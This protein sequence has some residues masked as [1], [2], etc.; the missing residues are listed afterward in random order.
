MPRLRPGRLGWDLA[1]LLIVVIASPAHAQ[2]PELAPGVAAALDAIRADSM[3]GHLSFLASDLLEGRDTPS[4]GLDLAAE[5]IAAQFRRAG[6]EPVGDDGYFQTARWKVVE[7]DPGTFRFEVTH[8]DQF[9]S[10]LPDRVSLVGPGPIDVSSPLVKLDARDVE[11]LDALP[12][13]KVKDKA[14]LVTPPADARARGN[15]FNRLRRLEPALAI[16]LEPGVLPSGLGRGRLIDPESAGGRLGGFA[17]AGPRRIAIHDPRAV[18]AITALA[19][20][21]EVGVTLRLGPPVER[22]VTLR[23]VVGRLKGADPAIAKTAVLLTAH[24]DHVGI[25]EP[26]D[27]DRIYNGANDDGSG[28]VS[29]IEIASALATLKQRPKRSIVFLCFFGEEKG[30]LGSRYYGRHP[31][32]PLADTVAQVNLEHMGRTDDTE[33][34]RV[35]G[36]S[37]TGYDYSTMV[38]A[39][40]KAGEATSIQVEKHPRNSDAFFGASDNQALADLG[41]PAHTVCTSFI[42]PEYHRPGDHW[43]KVDYANMARVDRMVALGLLI[44]ADDRDAPRWNAENARAARYAKAQERLKANGDGR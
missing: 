1:V 26:Q 14:V 32:I 10:V 4:R 27:G 9:I 28:T 38:D 6:L 35:G 42:F 40:R 23:N 44:L 17:P 25:G 13:E 37:I 29:V 24:Y 39:F 20:Q 19:G 11:A 3:K 33:G 43:E 30:L 18:A 15:F 5:Y 21:D 2:V 12:E 8:R 7:P 22:P 41:V 31:V 36:V 34:P 16:T